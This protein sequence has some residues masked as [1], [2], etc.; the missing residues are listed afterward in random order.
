MAKTRYKGNIFI[1]G[2]L[3]HY[4]GVS[5][6]LDEIASHATGRA[7]LAAVQSKALEL[8]IQPWTDKTPGAVTSNT[9]VRKA[10]LP[11]KTLLTCGRG[12]SGNEFRPNGQPILGEGGGSGSTISFTPDVTDRIHGPG[13]EPDEILLHELVHALRA[14]LG[15]KRC[16]AVGDRF[17]NI[18]EFGAILI[19]NIYRSECGRSGLRGDHTVDDCPGKS[20]GE[21]CLKPMAGNLVDAKAFYARFKAQMDRLFNSDLRSLGRQLAVEVNCDF[22]PLY[23]YG[24]WHWGL[25]E[26]VR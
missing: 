4:I 12:S 22:N 25:G 5:V 26:K 1:D 9:E 21:K 16:E 3:L 10:H 15:Q 14:L 11:G 19:T 2:E 7:V 6:Q 17:D 18:E 23:E 13:H 20:N 8:V 24:K